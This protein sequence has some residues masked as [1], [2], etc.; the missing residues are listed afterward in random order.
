MSKEGA[1]RCACPSQWW[2]IRTGHRQ[3]TYPVHG[4]ERA[5]QRAVNHYTVA[6]SRKGTGAGVDREK[7][8]P[9][10]RFGEKRKKKR[11]RAARGSYANSTAR[12]TETAPI[13]RRR[14]VRF[15]MRKGR[16]A[17][18]QSIT[19]E[20]S[21]QMMRSKFAVRQEDKCV[22][23]FAV[24]IRCVLSSS[25]AWEKGIRT[26]RLIHLDWLLLCTYLRP[27]IIDRLSRLCKLFSLFCICVFRHLTTADSR[28]PTHDQNY[29][30]CLWYHQNCTCLGICNT[31]R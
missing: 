10:Q 7:R 3:R 25:L 19:R 12:A 13:S 18:H 21:R 4:V 29:K 11:G 15:L 1:L 30:E 31:H 14:R 23:E 27:L 9:I 16:Q 8:A 2:S 22:E 24:M 26:I 6:K 28:Q 17:V 5:G 20:K